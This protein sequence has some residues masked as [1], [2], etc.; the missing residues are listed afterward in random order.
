MMLMMGSLTRFHGR[1]KKKK[2][3]PAR[4]AMRSRFRNLRRGALREKRMQWGDDR[5][6]QRLM[7]L[8][9]CVCVCVAAPWHKEKRK[10][11]QIHTVG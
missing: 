8:S 9:V 1:P 5:R 4:A 6:S 2:K 11:T 10:G 3:K 7:D